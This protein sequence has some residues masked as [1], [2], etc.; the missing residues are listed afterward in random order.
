MP[1]NK[2]HWEFHRLDLEQGWATPAGYQGGIQQK[3]LAS[4]I[5]LREGS[6]R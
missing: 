3:I 5:A 2:P 1:M 6:T 4:D